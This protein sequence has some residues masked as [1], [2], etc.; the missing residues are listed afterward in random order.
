[1]WVNLKFCILTQFLNNV[2][3]L[4]VWYQVSQSKP[5]KKTRGLKLVK[6][7]YSY[8]LN[9]AEV[10]QESQIVKHNLSI[11]RVQNSLHVNNEK[12][13]VHEMVQ[14]PIQFKK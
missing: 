13:N 8:V 4:E 5:C 6:L 7:Y 1:M 12:R 2:C 11:Q 3:E 9:L 14:S 10:W